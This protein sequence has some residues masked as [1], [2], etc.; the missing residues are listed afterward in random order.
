[1][2]KIRRALYCQL[3]GLAI[4]VVLVSVLSRFFPVVDFV[5]VL[6][7]RVMGWGP[8]GAIDYPLLFAVCN[9]LLLPGGVLAVGGG[10]FFGLG[11]GFLVVFAGNIIGAAISFAL[12]RWV[13]GQWVRQKVSQSPTLRALEPAVQREG[14]KIVLC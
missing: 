13:T 4:A 5:D 14:W 3:A 11:W 12:S 10:F 7:E 9:I 2:F 8:W 6:Q 1:M